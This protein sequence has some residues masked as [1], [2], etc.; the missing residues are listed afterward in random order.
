M[1][2]VDD[3]YGVGIIQV[4]EQKLSPDDNPFYSFKVM[5]ERRKEYL[6]LITPDEFLELFGD[7]NV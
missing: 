5:H 1:W 2:C 6:N 4:G 7:I 3:D